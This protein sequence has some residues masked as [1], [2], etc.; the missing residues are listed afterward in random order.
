[1][2]APRNYGCSISRL[3][4]IKVI[5]W[6]FWRSWCFVPAAPV[7]GATASSHEGLNTD[8]SLGVT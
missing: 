4:I 1:M 7:S 3:R 8:I 2:S 5:L 6:L